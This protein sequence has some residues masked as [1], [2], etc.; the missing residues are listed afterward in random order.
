[1]GNITNFWLKFQE[2]SS[3]NLSATQAI[4]T[5]DVHCFPESLKANASTIPQIRH[6]HFLTNSLQT[7]IHYVHML[8]DS[9]AVQHSVTHIHWYTVL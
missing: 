7:I 6:D 5:E 1:V 8:D 3:S 9:T 2:D 4:K